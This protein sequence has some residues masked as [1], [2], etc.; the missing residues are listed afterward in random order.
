MEAGVPVLDEKMQKFRPEAVCIVG[1]SIWETIFRVKSGGKKLG[2]GEFHYGWQDEEMWLGRK[3]D[4]DGEVVWEG[5]RTFVATTTSGL[6]AGMKREEKEAVWKELGDWIVAK[7]V[8]EGLKVDGE[9]KAM[10]INGA[11]R[12]VADQSDSA[13]QVQHDG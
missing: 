9:G 2:K 6:A 4:E 10:A 3:V 12:I 1:K 13:N 8:V 11:G 7:R 5:A